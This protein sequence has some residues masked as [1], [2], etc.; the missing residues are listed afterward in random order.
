MAISQKRGKTNMWGRNPRLLIIFVLSILSPFGLYD[1]A[2]PQS[3][4]FETVDKGETSYFNY[5]DPHFLGADMVI[6]D[7]KT[8]RWFWERH[9]PLTPQPISTKIDFSKE[10]V[11]IVLLGYQPS[12]GG[13]S[14]EISLVEEIGQDRF[15]KGI[16][17][18]TRES[19]EP[20]LMAAITNP[21]HIVKLKKFNSVIFQHQPIKNPCMENR[22]C[23]EEEYCKKT[24]G[25]CE[26]KGVCQPRPQACIEIYAPVCGCDGKTYGNECA[27]AA[28]GI[29]LLYHGE[30]DSRIACMKNEDCGP[31]E[32]C[33]FPDGKCS[34]SGMCTSKPDGCPRCQSARCYDPVCGCDLKT[35]ANSCEAYSNGVSILNLGQCGQQCVSSGGTISTALCCKSVD[36]FPNTCTQG[37]CGCSPE[38]S[39]QINICDCGPLKCFN[40]SRCVPFERNN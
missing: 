12:G 31:K 16:M 6:K 13:P 39:H 23:G 24:L 29:S 10:M 40:G 8:W 35:Y 11:L 1:V 33:L 5:A 17:V 2:L 3:I 27:A 20:G 28:I 34:G 25:D 26:E 38:N 18:Y 30:C 37:A 9:A 21:Y 7:E 32:F 15:L 19:K 4:S 36:H 22:Q 14:I